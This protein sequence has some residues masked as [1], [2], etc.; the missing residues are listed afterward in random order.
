MITRRPANN[1]AI[2]YVRRSAATGGDT[3]IVS[4]DVQRDATARQ[5]AA[6][7]LE[8]VHTISDDGVS[9]GDRQRFGRILQELKA[10]DAR[11][12][13][14]YHLDRFGRDTAGSLDTLEAF[15]NA[16]ITLHVAGR[17]VVEAQS[18]SGLLSFGVE[19]LVAH[20]Y[21][22]VCSE[23]IT[24][25]LARRK[26]EGRVYSNVPPFGFRA[27][28]DGHLVEDEHESRALE[29]TL[30]YRKARTPWRTI[31]KLLHAAGYSSRVGTPLSVATLRGALAPTAYRAQKLEEATA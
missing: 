9:G 20:H 3:R 21:R 29:L 19:A 14:V 12:L 31:P 11:H 17:G 13:I 28:D 23:K 2:L 18:S 25:A 8:I 15:S 16:G 24:A 30:A 4:L 10:N 26:R 5:A 27:T 1:R 7:G 22:V 6:A